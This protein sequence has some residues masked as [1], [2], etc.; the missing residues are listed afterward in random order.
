MTSIHAE[1]APLATS[2]ST[3]SE[4][5]NSE[6]DQFLQEATAL[7]PEAG[8]ALGRNRL[9]GLYTSWCFVSRGVPGPEDAFWAAMKQK[10]IRP[11]RTRLR[12]K[13]PAA[14]DYILSTYPEMV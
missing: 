14:T 9:Y 13:G 2:E 12:M 4:P 3:T 8:A 1:E 11:G 5:S 7:D 10:G 6:F